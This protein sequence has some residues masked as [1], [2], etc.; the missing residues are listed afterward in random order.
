MNQNHS[1]PDPSTVTSLKRHLQFF[2]RGA[3]TDQ[4]QTSM[5]INV[6]HS[7]GYLEGL[8]NNNPFRINML[9]TAC[10]VCPA[11]QCPVCSKPIR[12]SPSSFVCCLAAVSRHFAQGF[13]ERVR[14]LARKKS[15][16]WKPRSRTISAL[17]SCENQRFQVL[18]LKVRW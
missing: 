17:K 10:K 18:K 4:D 15:G 16:N 14:V 8:G 2:L 13:L 11:F 5:L 3:D 1:D 6:P 7:Y 9:K 12:R